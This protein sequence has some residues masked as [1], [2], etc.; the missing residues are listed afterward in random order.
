MSQI[1]LSEFIDRDHPMKISNKNP[2]LP[3]QTSDS[4]I[5]V[6]GLPTTIPKKEIPMDAQIDSLDGHFYVMQDEFGKL[7]SIDPALLDNSNSDNWISDDS[8]TC[9]LLCGAQFT[10]TRRRHHC[11]YCG[12]LFCGACTQNRAMV[13]ESLARVCDSCGVIL[14]PPGGNAKFEGLK[15]WCEANNCA[16][17]FTES[18]TNAGIQFLVSKMQSDS[19]DS[20]FNA[21]RTLYKLLPCHAP[22]LID[23]N[24]PAALL[25]HALECQD[26]NCQAKSLSVDL[27][28]TLFNTDSQGCNV[29]L[30]DYNIDIM[31]FF[32]GESIDQKRS[33][34]RLL[35]TL[36]KNENIEI[37]D[38]ISLLEIKDRWVS[39]FVLAAISLKTE[40]PQIEAEKIIPLLLSFLPKN[41]K[42]SSTVAARFYVSDILSRLSTMDKSYAVVLANNDLQSVVDLLYQN[43]PKSETDNRPETTVATNLSN[44]LLS[45][46]QIIA[47]EKREDHAAPFGQVL[48]PIYDVI[49][50]PNESK[51]DSALTKVQ[52][53]CFKLI[54]L[55]ATFED[56]VV[57]FKSE[58]ITSILTKAAEGE[59]EFS[60][61]ARKAL[62]SLKTESAE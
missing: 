56:C 54:Q 35:Y 18:P 49:G 15:K 57:S 61:E 38:P 11:R 47:E 7:S 5:G 55:F 17:L 34:A 51:A 60:I 26:E 9:C 58:Q 1:K 16:E 24:I 10:L 44:V 13:G 53:T 21:I 2:N 23:S 43:L 32:S 14:I 41:N 20:H 28:V 46:W 52:I 39:A 42:E 27:F 19:P 45:A 48:M 36:V 8:S 59:T 29:N 62:D 50:M 37:P 3:N 6:D 31:P 22:A 4:N 25:K 33:A 40:L 30:K 12:L